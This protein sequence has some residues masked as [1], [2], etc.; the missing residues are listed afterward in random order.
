M[1]IARA[2]IE[3]TVVQSRRSRHAGLNWHSPK[4]V[5]E[6]FLPP[7]WLQKIGHDTYKRYLNR[8]ANAL[9]RRDRKRGGSYTVRQAMDAIHQAFWES[10]GIDPYDGMEM[11]GELLGTYSNEASKERRGEY[12]REFARLPT[13]DHVYGKPDLAFE[14]VSWQTNDA[15]GDMTPDDADGVS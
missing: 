11:K 8:K 3:K 14:I 10:D 1:S 12:K 2:L 7:A 6:E 4:P 15:K 9:M 5:S 13:V